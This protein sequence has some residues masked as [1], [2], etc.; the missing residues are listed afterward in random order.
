MDLTLKTTLYAVVALLL[1]SEAAVNS[2]S[3]GDV[4]GDNDLVKALQEVDTS[5]QKLLK[6][7]DAGSD[8]NLHKKKA[9]KI[10]RPPEPEFHKEILDELDVVD[11]PEM[12]RELDNINLLDQAATDND[13]SSRELRILTLLKRI[14]GMDASDD[15]KKD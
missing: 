9:T 8:D 11:E 4:Q 7:L 3:T 2:K 12:T 5:I 6:T 15:Q 1:I 14:I 13:G 10:S